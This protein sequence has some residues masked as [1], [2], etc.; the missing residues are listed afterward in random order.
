M[1]SVDLNIK[2]PKLQEKIIT[3]RDFR[4]LRR[5]PKK[6]L[7][8]LVNVKWEVFRDMEDVDPIEEFLTIKVNEF[9]DSV[10]PL[11]SKKV[12]QKRYS[13]PKEVQSAIK[14]RK[15]LKKKFQIN[16][17]NNIEDFKLEEQFKKQRNYCNKLFKNAVRENSGKNI[18]S[19][20]SGKDIWNSINDILK[21]ESLAKHSIKIQ[22][23]DQ[24]IEDPLQIAEAF[25]GFFKEKVE[26]LAASI[27]TYCAN[28]RTPYYTDPDYD[29][30]I[31]LKEK[32]RGSNLKFNL[33]TVS[34]QIVQKILRQ[35]KPKKSCGID[36]ITS[37]ILKI[38]S[39]VLVV[40]LT[41]I[42]NYSIVTGKH[43]SNWKI[44]QSD[45]FA[46]KR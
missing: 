33:K 36:G 29:P 10:A 9:M 16:K 41:Y 19:A 27:K 42:I 15:D 17:Q 31:R 4:K 5:N 1:I 30:F 20:S 25:N 6:F 35:L 3:S 8:E 22:T 13:L 43:P 23:E 18:T 7:K 46:Q 44:A 45:S 2:I 34:E 40:P 37:E 32:L 24:L 26:R 12:K 14:V 21:P 38:C 39:E 11:K 28:S